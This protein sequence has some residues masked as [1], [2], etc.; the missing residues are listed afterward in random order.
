MKPLIAF[1]LSLTLSTA[2]YSF[3]DFIPLESWARAIAAYRLAKDDSQNP[4]DSQRTIMDIIREN[5]HCVTSASPSDTTYCSPVNLALLRKRATEYYDKLASE[6]DQNL[7]AQH[8][9]S[10]PETASVVPCHEGATPATGHL[11]SAC[12][13][14]LHNQQMIPAEFMD[15][16][17]IR[18][19][20]LLSISEMAREDMRIHL[21]LSHMDLNRRIRAL[22]DAGFISAAPE[23]LSV[24]TADLLQKINQLIGRDKKVTAFSCGL[25]DPEASHESPDEL[26]QEITKFT[27]ASVNLLIDFVDTSM[28]ILFGRRIVPVLILH[29][30]GHIFIVS[31]ITGIYAFQDQ[32]T[33]TL[34]QT[35]EEIGESVTTFLQFLFYYLN[36]EGH[37]GFVLRKVML[38]TP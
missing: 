13:L 20:Q 25:F 36:F 32:F 27:G 7:K 18:Q 1:S 21:T 6:R 24:D 4:Q 11:S 35:P 2:C 17:H 31:S 10:E 9:L 5:F 38:I 23:A 15:R 8:Q 29:H 33:A 34:E 30:E 37:H 14:L 28:S 19:N 22:Y 26:Y 16:Y 3:S 12:P